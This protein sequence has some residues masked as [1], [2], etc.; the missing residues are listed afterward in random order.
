MTRLAHLFLA[1]SFAAIQCI[2]PLA[3]AHT[4]G[5]AEHGIHLPETVAE[6][7]VLAAEASCGTVEADESPAVVV[8][9]GKRKHERPSPAWDP[10]CTTAAVA[11]PDI[12]ITDA[13]PVLVATP[14]PA[15]L[16]A[17]S[18][19]THYPQ[20]PPAVAPL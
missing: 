4:A 17:L 6:A 15:G 1:L 9:D 12:A 10:I 19:R 13:L 8:P 11:L 7:H 2:A 18:F 16:P 14:D 3:H 20:A 5:S